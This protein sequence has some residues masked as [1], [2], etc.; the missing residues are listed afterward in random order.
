MN[1]RND[2]DVGSLINVDS[3]REY[4]PIGPQERRMKWHEIHLLSSGCVLC[5]EK[6]AVDIISYLVRRAQKVRLETRLDITGSHSGDPST[7]ETGDLNFECDLKRE[8]C[9]DLNRTSC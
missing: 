5:S 9:D 4:L 7:A 3:L 6:H 8:R 2:P 1:I